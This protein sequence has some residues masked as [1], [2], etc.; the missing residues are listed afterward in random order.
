M[1]VRIADLVN[2]FT[3]Q[4]YGPVRT[5]NLQL[6]VTFQWC[7][8]HSCCQLKFVHLQSH[9]QKWPETL[10]ICQKCLLVC[11][12]GVGKAIEAV[13]MD[14]LRQV[15]YWT[16]RT[17]I[18]GWGEGSL[19]VILLMAIWS[20]SSIIAC[21]LHSVGAGTCYTL[22]GNTTGPLQNLVICIIIK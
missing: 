18:K 9:W 6:L 20:P 13:F 3:A 16:G 15:V 17:T 14:G 1:E 12:G 19:Q 5:V 4:S 10:C 2:Y 8:W 22:A 11:T 7:S 21:N